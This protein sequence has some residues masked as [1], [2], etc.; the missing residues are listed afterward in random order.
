MINFDERGLIPAI[1]QDADKGDVLMVGYLNKES[2]RRTF[3]SGNVWFYSRSRQKLWEKGE[4]SGHFLRV[5]SIQ[6]DCD[7]DTL[8]I[9]AHPEGP[10]CHTLNPTCFFQE[11][12]EESVK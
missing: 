8:L 5:R 9:K 4:T 7:G 6:V 10:V 1:I 12:T 11:V 2:L 3:Q